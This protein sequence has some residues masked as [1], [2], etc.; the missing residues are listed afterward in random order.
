M[1]PLNHIGSKVRLDGLM[2]SSLRN[3]YVVI[4]K[5]S[6]DT[7]Y[8]FLYVDVASLF[9]RFGAFRLTISYSYDALECT[10]TRCKHQRART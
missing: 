1:K 8:R 9:L 2:G 5:G 4:G 3:H 10:N 6:I 7:W